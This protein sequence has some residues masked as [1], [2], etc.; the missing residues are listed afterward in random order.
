[1]QQLIEFV[2]DNGKTVLIQVDQPTEDHSATRSWGDR[3]SGETTTRRAV[4]TFEDAV[5]SV[6]PAAEAVVDRMRSLAGGPDEMRVEFGL[7]LSAEAGAFIAKTAVAANFK[8]SLTW[9]R[10]S[11]RSAESGA[12]D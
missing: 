10:D 1:M 8:I 7:E 2:L 5:D 3:P 11:G 12:A 9:R 4:H 6:K